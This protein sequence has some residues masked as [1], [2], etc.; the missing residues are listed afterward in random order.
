MTIQQK[1]WKNKKTNNNKT[2]R[3]YLSFRMM[4]NKKKNKLN[5]MKL[6][7]STD[8]SNLIATYLSKILLL[9]LIGKS[10]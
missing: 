10:K 1:K 4:E 9:S 7:V 6:S 5:F 2:P 3:I 8:T